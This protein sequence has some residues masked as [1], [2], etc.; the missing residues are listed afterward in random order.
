MV[1]LT[2]N[3]DLARESLKAAFVMNDPQSVFLLRSLWLL[4]TT[5]WFR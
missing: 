4:G 1:G 2:A 3:S 5:V